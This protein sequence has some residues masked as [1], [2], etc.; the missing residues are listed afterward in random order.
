MINHLN[1]SSHKHITYLHKSLSKN[2]K[3]KIS[4]KN[5][6]SYVLNLMWC[7]KHKQPHVV[8]KV[9]RLANFC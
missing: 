4:L 1:L 8:R 6:L 9:K 5:E 2:S 3:F 7:D